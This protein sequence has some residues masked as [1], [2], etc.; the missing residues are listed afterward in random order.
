MPARI[1]SLSRDRID[2]ILTG[3]TP[4]AERMWD[5]VE[6]ARQA[7][8][9]LVLPRIEFDTS[10][11]R[12]DD[13]LTEYRLVAVELAKLHIAA[14]NRRLRIEAGQRLLNSEYLEDL[15]KQRS[16]EE[17]GLFDEK[18]RPFW[19]M[20]VARCT[21]RKEL[22]RL[23]HREEFDAREAELRTEENRRRRRQ[24]EAHGCAL[25]RELAA[26]V[27]HLSDFYAA[28]LDRYAGPLGFSLDERRSQ[29]DGPVFSKSL[30]DS[31]DL[32]LS[33]ERL[34]WWPGKQSG[35]GRTLLS[36]QAIGETK[37]P[38]VAKTEQALLIEFTELIPYFDFL[39]WQFA[40]LDELEAIVNAQMFLLALVLGD[41][42]EV[43]RKGVAGAS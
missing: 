1:A 6:M 41:I 38:R 39:Y 16:E 43:V 7:G 4:L 37:P 8:W 9:D 18:N 21:R 10:F 14:A 19:A 30:N 36:L 27:D 12:A 3:I 40:T 34:V 11:C 29:A 13:E 17:R 24:A 15:R 32:C 25:A 2:E 42:E 26:D 23:E 20:Q 22:W 35:E 31:W 5:F 33:A 28:L